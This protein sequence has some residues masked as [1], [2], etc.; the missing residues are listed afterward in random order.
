[1]V[2]PLWGTVLRLG[3]AQLGLLL[4]GALAALV[5][6]FVALPVITCSSTAAYRQ[7]FGLRDRTGLVAPLA[8]AA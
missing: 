8:Q 7:M 4:L 1:V 6:V 3:M 2:D 5:G